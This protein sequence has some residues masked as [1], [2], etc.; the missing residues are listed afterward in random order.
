MICCIWDT[1]QIKVNLGK[2]LI[3]S[4]IFIHSLNIWFDLNN[5]NLNNT[6]KRHTHGQAT[7]M[8]ERKYVEPG[9]RVQS[10]I[11]HDQLCN[12]G[13]IIPSPRGCFLICKMGTIMPTS[14]GCGE[15]K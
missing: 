10:Q 11:F 12:L 7:Q 15:A 4:H 3:S 9:P 6:A 2:K 5:G 1:L 14:K 13:Q 8:A